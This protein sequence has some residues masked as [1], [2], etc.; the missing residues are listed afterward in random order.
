MIQLIL[1]GVIGI[2]MFFS[3]LVGFIQGFRKN[4]YKLIATILFWTIFWC[5]APFVKGEAILKSTMIYDYLASFLPPIDGSTCTT[6]FDY[7]IY[8]LANML[9]I[10]H[11]M[12][13]DVA[14]QST[15]I[16]ILQNIVKI[17]YLIVYAIVFG[18]INK[19]VYAI[20][21]KKR[22]KISKRYL[23]KLE[24]KQEKYVNVMELKIKVLKSKLQE[25]KNNFE[26]IKFSNH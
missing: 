15:L 17:V 16:A 4:V 21:F 7:I 8:T 23:R 19:L 10:S 11:E 13:E 24:R 1:V 6:L 20:F 26:T 3:L 5:T 18:I 2:I 12:L 14:I 25:K 22:F 9:D